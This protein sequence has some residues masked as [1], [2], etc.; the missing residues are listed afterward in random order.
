MARTPVRS[1]RSI[2]SVRSVRSF[3]RRIGIVAACAALATVAQ[4]ARAADDIKIGTVISLSG[5]FGIYGKISL[6]GF[7]MAL[8]ESG[9]KAAGRKIVVMKEDDK[10]DPKYAIQLARRLIHDE[11]VDF[12]YGPIATPVAAAI[13]NEVHNSKTYLLVPNASDDG[14]TREMCSPY[15]IRTSFSS[16]TQ[17]APMGDYAAKNIGKRAAVVGAN[18]GAG[19]QQTGAFMD[20]FK[21]AGGTIVHEEWPA[22][23]TADYASI[24]TNIRAKQ[25]KVDVVY[26]MLIG[27]MLPAF[28]NQWAQSGMRDKI[29]VAGATSMADELYFAAIKDRAVGQFGSGP[30]AATALDTPRNN[31]F[32]ALFKRKYGHAPTTVELSG[33]DAGKL[34]VA[35]IEKV[36]G[37][38]K[39]KA[40][41]RAAFTS[42]EIDSPRGYFKIDPKTGN[43][44]DNIYI[45]QVVQLPDGDMGH[46]LLATYDKYAD[47]GTGCKM[48]AP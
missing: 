16:W 30:Y 26:F 25:D 46:K 15:V 7:D 24:I 17:N 5:L 29:K 34:L 45:T 3:A 27:A 47:P 1:V 13:R 11:K 43:V 31:A 40:A 41:L 44:I 33:Y 10:T 19:R 36:N 35:V 14:V 32:V 37:N 39:N 28:V 42:V 9:H 23:G 12:L 18:F 4:P 22:L 6:E 20:T 21:K 2:R 38:L 48:T 8:E